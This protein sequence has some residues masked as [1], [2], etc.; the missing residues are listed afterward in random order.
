M[1]VQVLKIQYFFEKFLYSI[2]IIEANSRCVLRLA[3]NPG[4][5]VSRVGFTRDK[6]SQIRDVPDNP[7]LVATL[8]E[9]EKRK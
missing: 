9:T 1:Q 7:G 3:G 5:L 4:Q 8:L 6:G 2:C